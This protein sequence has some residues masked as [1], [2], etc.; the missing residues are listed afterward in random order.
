MVEVPSLLCQIAVMKD[1]AD[2]CLGRL[3]DLLQYLLRR[4]PRNT[5][6]ASRFDPLR[7]L[8]ARAPASRRRRPSQGH[9]GDALWGDRRAAAR[10]FGTCRSAFATLDVGGVDRPGQG[11]A[12]SLIPS[13]SPARVDRLL[14]ERPRGSIVARPLRRWPNPR[15]YRSA[16]RCA[17]EDPSNYPDKM[18]ANDNLD[19]ILR[20]RR[21]IEARLAEGG[22]RAISTLARAQRARA[23]GRRDQ[24]SARKDEGARR[25]LRDARRS[26]PPRNAGD[27]GG[28]TRRGRSRRGAIKQAI[29][30]ALLPKDAADESNAILEVRAGTGGDE[31]AL[32]AGDLFRMYVKYA[33]PKAGRSRCSR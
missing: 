20:G 11:N 18:A 29:R 2:F 21:E 33:E 30:I 3:D 6:V 24:G 27:G 26:R 13:G 7:W 25:S 14:A 31:A 15:A 10:R 5:R 4:R 17:A 23:R 28:R 9:A 16:T 22:R 8:P 19:L 12:L 32:F 1:A